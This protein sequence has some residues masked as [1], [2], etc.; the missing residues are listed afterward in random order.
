MDYYLSFFKEID[1]L[2]SRFNQ[3][4]ARSRDLARFGDALLEPR[5]VVRATHRVI[6]IVLIFERHYIPRISSIP[7]TELAGAEIL[8]SPLSPLTWKLIVC[9]TEV[10]SLLPLA[11]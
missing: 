10:A 8:I 1:G 4:I 2:G 6:L 5:H 7:T 11:S 3:I 9:R